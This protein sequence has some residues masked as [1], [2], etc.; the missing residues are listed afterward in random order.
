MTATA[1]APAPL[2]TIAGPDPA[3]ALPLLPVWRRIHD[4]GNAMMLLYT[5]FV[6]ED[7]AGQTHILTG[8]VNFAG[9]YDFCGGC[10]V[11][12]FNARSA[13]TNLRFTD[14]QTLSRIAEM[15]KVADYLGPDWY[16]KVQAAYGDMEDVGGAYTRQTGI[17]GM[18][19]RFVGA[20]VFA[21]LML[22]AGAS[23]QNIVSFWDKSAGSTRAWLKYGA[24]LFKDRSVRAPRG[25]CTQLSRGGQWGITGAGAPAS[26]YLG[27]PGNIPPAAIN[28]LGEVNTVQVFGYSPG[29]VRTNPN[30]GNAVSAGQVFLT[31]QAPFKDGSTS[32]VFSRTT[33]ADLL[34]K[35]FCRDHIHYV[36]GVTQNYWYSMG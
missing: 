22:T 6:A 24:R 17:S 27:H 4:G 16:A 28:T 11:T 29:R 13:P 23:N 8:G 10:Y 5:S 12:S 15:P 19:A 32:L 36:G 18:L 35:H 33:R 21:R 1:A 14:R 25:Y 26:L 7:P 31:S 2:L 34:D 20:S 30:S 3:Q 9:I